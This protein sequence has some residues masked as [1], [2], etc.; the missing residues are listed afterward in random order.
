[1]TL[2]VKPQVGQVKPHRRHDAGEIR[3]G[4]ES[5]F[6]HSGDQ[7]DGGRHLRVVEAEPRLLVVVVGL[8]VAGVDDGE[9]GCGGRSS[10][11]VGISVAGGLGRRWCVL[12]APGDVWS[13]M[14][15]SVGRYGDRG[16]DGDIVGG[17]E[18]SA[19]VGL[20]PRGRERPRKKGETL[21]GLTAVAVGVEAGSGTRRRRRI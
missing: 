19:E 16:H 3:D 6:C 20:G 7:M 21:R 1:M 12:R 17:V 11:A 2:G 10:G 8:G 15:C 4:G 9:L 14:V 18:L 13:T 5:A